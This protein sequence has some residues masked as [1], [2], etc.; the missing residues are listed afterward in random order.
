EPAPDAWF[1][2]AG[3][4]TYTGLFGRDVLT[5]GWQAAL[6]GP[7]MMR[8]ALAALAARQ[9]TSDSAW[10]DAEPGKLLHEAR[11]GPLAELDL[12][13]QRAYYGEQTAQAMFV[14]T[15]SEY[16]HW[17]G[18]TIAIAH[19]RDAL[20]RMFEWAVRYGDRDGDGLLEYA[21]R[22]P[23]GL[24][25][26]AWKDSDEA[27]RY[28]D[29]RLVPDPIATIEEQAYHYIALQRMAEILLVLDDEEGAHRFLSEAQRVYEQVNERFW[30]ED[31]QY[32]AV[33]LDPEKRPVRTI[34]SNPG[35]A[36]AAGIVPLDRARAVADR[37][38]A[39][40]LFSGWGMRTLSTM[41]PSYNPFA[42][43]LGT[44]WPVENATFALGLKRYGLDEHVERLV[45][46]MLDASMHFEALRLPEALAG[47]ARSADEPPTFY[48]QANAPQAWS[49]SAIVQLIQVQLG[50]IPFAAANMLA[51]VRPRLPPW[52]PDVVLRRVRVGDAVVSLR[53]LRNADGSAAHEVL[54]RDGSLHVLEVPP[55]A[56]LD[57]GRE[58]LLGRLERW[59]V[60]HAPGTTARAL[61]IA[62]GLAQ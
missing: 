52:L 40:D 18:D 28:P 15:L 34:T 35:H 48:P 2:N 4:P 59:L 16:W 37:L 20:H 31:E 32:Y 36:L 29:G 27:I 23:K 19:Y 24:K 26:Q 53:F 61:R 45:S 3:V 13:P 30:M 46:A 44:V 8:G 60:E 54:D 6:L 51:L 25:N 10:R 7:E 33:A 43:H 9:A 1:P 38:L 62:I 17:T 22:S 42:Y 12:I 21:R 49:A 57:R 14:V 50:L 55:P 5:T 11:R 47:H 39:E 56:D 41:H 58:H